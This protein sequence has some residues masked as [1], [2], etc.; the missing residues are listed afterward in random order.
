MPIALP[1]GKP[2][3]SLQYGVAQTFPYLLG[4]FLVSDFDVLLSSTLKNLPQSFRP[5]NFEFY[6]LID[7]SL[8]QVKP[9]CSDLKIG[10]NLV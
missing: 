9:R 3:F 8:L 1:V 2:G 10:S 7:V 6:S 5:L 4:P